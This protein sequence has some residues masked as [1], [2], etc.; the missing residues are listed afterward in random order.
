MISIEFLFLL[1]ELIN[2]SYYKLISNF[3][4]NFINNKNNTKI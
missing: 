1:I 2:Y 3:I 4:T